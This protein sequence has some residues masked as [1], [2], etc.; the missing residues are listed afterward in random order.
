MKVIPL[1]RHLYTFWTSLRRYT[2][3]LSGPFRLLITLLN[4]TT[5][6]RYNHLCLSQHHD[7]YL[8]Y[9]SHKYTAGAEELTIT[10]RYIDLP[11]S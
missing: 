3:R 6:L 7:D 9:S 5:V 11:S 1:Q 4:A 8:I 10:V 2:A